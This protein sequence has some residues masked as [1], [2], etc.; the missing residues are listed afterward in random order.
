MLCDMTGNVREWCQDA[1][2]KEYPGDG[3]DESAMQAES[4]S[5]R[6]LRGS[7]WLGAP[8]ASRSADRFGFAQQGRRD[9]IGFRVAKALSQ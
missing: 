2:L 1:A 3:A 4:R 7:S 5:G 9:F 8:E 6:M